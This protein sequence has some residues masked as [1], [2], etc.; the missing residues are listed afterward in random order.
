MSI[1]AK[2]TKSI[3]CNTCHYFGDSFIF[4]IR[5][6]FSAQT[7]LYPNL[8][9]THRSPTINSFSLLGRSLKSS[10]YAADDVITCTGLL[11]ARIRVDNQTKVKARS[12]MNKLLMGV[13]AFLLTTYLTS[14]PAWLGAWSMGWAATP[15]SFMLDGEQRSHTNLHGGGSPV[16]ILPSTYL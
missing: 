11:P 8:H 16:A 9:S 6:P 12:G 2:T 5:A 13:Q 15:K 4:N 10:H 14:Y 3:F 1:S 7:L